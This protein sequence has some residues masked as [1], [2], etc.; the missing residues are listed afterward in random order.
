MRVQELMTSHPICC[1]PDTN[2]AAATALLWNGDCG[3]VAVVDDLGQPVGIIT[4]RDICIAL[5][6]RDQRASEVMVDEVM[7][8]PA[9]ACPAG[10]DVASALKLMQR[11]RVRRLAVVDDEGT[12]VGIIAL[13]DLVLHAGEEGLSGKLVLSTAQKLCEHT[14]KALLVVA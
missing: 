11:N 14:D 5:G 13:N 2:L 4:D 9:V 3:A 12:L 8:T 1:R 6:T 7:H 10:E